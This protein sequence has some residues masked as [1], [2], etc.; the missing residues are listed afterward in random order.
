M[1]KADVVVVGAGLAGLSCALRLQQ[2]GREVT[3]L[4]ASDRAGGRVRTDL[5]DGYRIDNGFAVLLTAYPDAK[6]IFDYQALDLQP[7]LP[8]A[9]IFADGKWQLVG[10]PFR[11]PSDLWSTLVADVGTVM[12]K[13]RILLWRGAVVAAGDRVFTDRDGTLLDLLQSSYGFSPKMVDRFFR[14]FLGGVF[15]DPT[16]ST[17]RRMA[18]FVWQM[19]SAGDTAV[20]RNGIGA[21]PAQLAARLAPGS[22]QTGRRV[23]TVKPGEV[24]TEDGERFQAGEVVIATELRQASAWLPHHAPD[25]GA[26]GA[27]YL[28]FDAPK[29]PS[30]QPILH[31]NGEG[32]GPVNNCHVVTDLIPSAAPAGR[33]LISVTCLG[34]ER[35]DEAAVRAQLAGWFGGQVEEWRLIDARHIPHALPRQAVGDLN[36]FERSVRVERGL[37]VCGDHRDQSSI[38]G[39][40]RS[41]RRAAEAILGG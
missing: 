1:G 4:E 41:G 24:T 16:L 11:H 10:D 6:L 27:H 7:F 22:L 25:R 31:L 15:F 37:L 3:L 21:M 26:S 29:S 40:L 28:S 14:P 23:A 13:A 32:V 17:S 9:R 19:F 34:A 20:P 12:D 2:A 35:P 39:A 18:N 30:G 8:G 36:P 5:I 33:A 38:Q